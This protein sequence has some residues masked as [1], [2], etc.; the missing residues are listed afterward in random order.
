[1][2]KLITKYSFSAADKT[3]TLLDYTTLK[4]EGV[5][6]I[7]NV[8]DN[9]I[10]YNF[11]DATKGGT[12]SG[13]V[14]SLDYDTATM[15]N[16]D[17]LQ[18]FYDD[19][20]LTMGDDS[21]VKIKIGDEPVALKGAGNI[22]IAQ[23][24]TGELLVIDPLLDKI[25]GAAPVFDGKGGIRTSLAPDIIVNSNIYTVQSYCMMNLDG[26][27]AAVI[28]LFGTFAGT[29]TFEATA[30]GGDWTTIFGQVINT[31]GAP[32]ATSTAAGIFRFNTTGL[33]AIR[34]RYST[35]TSGVCQVF[36]RGTNSIPPDAIGTV[37]GSG[38]FTISGAVTEA[39]LDAMNSP[40][41]RPGIIAPTAPT[42]QTAGVAPWA[43]LTPQ[44]VTRMR[45]EAA[46]SEKLPFTQIPYTNE[47]SVK[48][49]P[50]FQM[51]EKVWLQLAMHNQLF[52]VANN[53]PLPNGWETI[54]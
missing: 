24:E 44:I 9:V 42:L 32:A 40:I 48:D 29:I 7:T 4:L 37:A 15:D 46:G 8:T 25:F 35:Y 36:M 1:M 23:L 27:T 52:M 11:A 17:S 12:V 49:V 3:V 22:P 54:A 5:L 53:I 41:A 33:Y 21:P 38:T 28:Q 19:G 13:N 2:K 10:I 43:Y 16:T 18:I 45:T 30:N 34:A 6:L 50:L 51:L 31:V 26:R 20:L 14:I 47:M 39:T